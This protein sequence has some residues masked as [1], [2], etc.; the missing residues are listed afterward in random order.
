MHLRHPNHQNLRLLMGWML[1]LVHHQ[2][3]L[4]KKK[5]SSLRLFQHFHHCHHRLV[6]PYTPFQQ[7]H[8]KYLFSYH[9]R[10]RLLRFHRYH[11]HHLQQLDIQQKE[12]HKLEQSKH[13]QTIDQPMLKGES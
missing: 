9:Q 6:S 5:Q 3:K 8:P 11:H 13:Y 1:T 12:E 10:H 7:K 2:L 4:L